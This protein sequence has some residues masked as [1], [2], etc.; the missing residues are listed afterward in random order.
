MKFNN[1]LL[2]GFL[3]DRYTNS[4]SHWNVQKPE[5]VLVADDEIFLGT[6]SK[7][8]PYE[9]E[10][11]SDRELRKEIVT[12]HY[13]KNLSYFILMTAKNDGGKTYTATSMVVD[14]LVYRMG[15]HPIFIDPKGEYCSFRRRNLNPMASSIWARLGMTINYDMKIFPYNPA[16]IPHR[17]DMREKKFKIRLQDITIQDLFTLLDLNSSTNKD[18]MAK[19]S[20]LLAAIDKYKKVSQRGL[21]ENDEMNNVA[22]SFQR[23]PPYDKLI[24]Y[25]ARGRLKEKDM[26][27]EVLRNLGY[28]NIIGTSNK[29]PNFAK[30]IAKS[31]EYE[32]RIPVMKTSI[33]IDLYPIMRGIIHVTLR[34]ITNAKLYNTPPINFPILVMIDEFNVVALKSESE[35]RPFA[36]I[37]NQFRSEGVGLMG[38]SP[39]PKDINETF[40][41]QCDY[42]ILGKILYTSPE[43]EC[44]KKKV[45]FKNTEVNPL[46]ELTELEDLGKGKYPKQMA[47]INRDGE[48]IKFYPT[49]SLFHKEKRITGRV[50][51]IKVTVPIVKPEE[52]PLIDLD[53]EIKPV[54]NESKPVA[55]K[56]NVKDDKKDIPLGRPVPRFQTKWGLLTKIQEK[57]MNAIPP[58][59]KILRS[60]LGRNIG[61]GHSHI[62]R[63]MIALIHKGLVKIEKKRGRDS[64][65]YIM[66]NKDGNSDVTTAVIK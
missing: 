26:L 42:W 27:I 54:S 65:V 7:L 43:Y 50:G 32:I 36:N 39:S 22:L 55:A 6:R 9:I 52:P 12:M 15:V 25:L 59:G 45:S 33:D 16:I 19:R 34:N 10:Q 41:Q 30:I 56:E 17:K 47:I 28:N 23:S 38:I 21:D 2:N 14:N 53:K 48:V 46:I 31:S 24:K 44:A 8:E 18:I 51:E 64:R 66:L 62:A 49:V 63:Y 37:L 57:I 58:E 11:M 60:E 5:N 40:I 35:F 61:L 4:L 20:R 3:N 29:M 1:L 13:D